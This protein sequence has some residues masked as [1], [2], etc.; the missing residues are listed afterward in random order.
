MIAGLLALTVIAI[1]AA[2]V[3]ANDAADASRQHLISLSRQL[4]T[5][6]LII[7]SG[8]PLTAR[9]L[10]VAAWR[11]YPTDQAESVMTTLLT[12]QQRDG[13]LPGDPANG[14]ATG[15]A[16]SPDGKLLAT[17]YGDGTVRLWNPA[18][19]QAVG[20]PLQAGTGTVSGAAA[21]AFSRNGKLL[22]T[23][24]ADGTVRVWNPAGGQAPSHHLYRRR[25][26]ERG[27]VQPRRQAPGYR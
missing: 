20:A 12:E 24:D 16:F 9:Q 8:D 5:E 23:A 15:A 10:A 2:G 22:A 27:S 21:V 26:R 25:R 1:S 7:D 19:E 3:A 11:V 13:I 6:S 14:G 17:A 18:T 4:A